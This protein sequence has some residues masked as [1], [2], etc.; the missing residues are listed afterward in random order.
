MKRNLPY[1]A[2]ART[3]TF[4]R[5]VYAEDSYLR[6]LNTLAPNKFLAIVTK[7]TDKNRQIQTLSRM[8]NRKTSEAGTVHRLTGNL[9]RATLFN[10]SSVLR[11]VYYG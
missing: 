6:L 3:H 5:T 4:F 8:Q 10:G 7:P 11:C 2:H 9:R 1:F